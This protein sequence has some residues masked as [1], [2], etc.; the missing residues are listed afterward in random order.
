MLIKKAI[1]AAAMA[2]LLLLVI[3]GCS[4]NE[5]NPIAPPTTPK[6][7]TF[8]LKEIIFPQHMLN[9]TDAHAQQAIALVTD[10]LDFESCGCVFAPPTEAEAVKE[11][12]GEWEY[13]WTTGDLTQTLQISA[14][15]GRNSWKVFYDGSQNGTN[16]NNWRFMD[17]VQSTDLSSG[18]ITL[19]KAGTVETEMEW[20]W[21]TLEQN[22]YKL[23]K[24][25]YGDPP[26]KIDISVKK[27]NSGKIDK[28]APNTSGSMVYD[29]KFS[30]AA[31]GTG[32]YW[33]FEDGKQTGFGTWQ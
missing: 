9:S 7:P 30:W 12:S 31:D 13:K 4:S 25:Y 2:S 33:T 11:T 29:V 14:V 26:Y 6:A 28:F 20:V 1:I 23:I 22:E 17:V 15:S 32:S 18:H 16:F 24:Q 5:E 27:D 8:T 10:A 3:A 19:F 21:Y